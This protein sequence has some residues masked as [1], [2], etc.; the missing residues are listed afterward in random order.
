MRQSCART[1]VTEEPDEVVPH[2]RICGNWLHN[3]HLR[4]LLKIQQFLFWFP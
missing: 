1:L 4:T 2:V 3:T